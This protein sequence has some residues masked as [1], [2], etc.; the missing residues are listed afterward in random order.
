L[1]RRK[2]EY[3]MGLRDSRFPN[4]RFTPRDNHTRNNNIDSTTNAPR[5]TSNVYSV[6]NRAP[7]YSNI[8]LAQRGVCFGCRE[9]G[10]RLVG[11]PTINEMLNKGTLKKLESGRLELPEGMPLRRW[12]EETL[13]EA[14]NNMRSAARTH[15]VRWEVE[16][17]SAVEDNKCGTYSTSGYVSEEESEEE[18]MRAYPAY[19]TQREGTRK[20]TVIFDGVYPSKGQ[21]AREE[22]KKEQCQRYELRGERTYTP[23]SKSPPINTT[24]PPAPPAD[25]VIK[26]LRARV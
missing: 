23:V 17:E 24:I 20:Q 18:E 2:N 4:A 6:P 13:L 26:R 25:P 7:I 22:M 14:Y 11:C 8:P 15:F 19:R 3:S 9:K 1:D 5:N 10:H 12:G 21:E 16:S